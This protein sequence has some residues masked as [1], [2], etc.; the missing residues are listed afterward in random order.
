M[1]PEVAFEDEAAGAGI[2]HRGAGGKVG[3][4]GEGIEA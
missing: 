3:F 4:A 1:M 2:D